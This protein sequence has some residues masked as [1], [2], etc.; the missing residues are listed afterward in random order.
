MSHSSQAREAN[1]EYALK[2]LTTEL[3]NNWIDSAYFTSDG[4]E[5]GKVFDT[6]W[7]ELEASHLIR[8]KYPIGDLSRYWLLPQGW[9][10][11]IQLLGIPEQPDFKVR[12]GRLCETL[13]RYVKGRHQ[14]NV[15]DVENI[16]V[17]AG[18]A[19]GFICNCIDTQLIELYLSSYSA[20]WM[21]DGTGKGTTLW[22][23][24]TV[25]LTLI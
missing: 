2:L 3:G 20:T 15:A 4:P 12:L 23:P 1:R 7:D 13:K 25:G 19:K 11:G 22:I 16:A 17:E 6:T 5:Y 21:K 9:L 24:R 18:L 10:K 14:Y 8:A